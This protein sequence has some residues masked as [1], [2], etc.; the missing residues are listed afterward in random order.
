MLNE[1]HAVVLKVGPHATGIVEPRQTRKGA[2]VRRPSRV[3]WEYLTGAGFM[4]RS[5]YGPFGGRCTAT[6]YMGGPDMAPQTPQRSSRPGGAV[7]LLEGFRE[8]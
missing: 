1:P 6:D 4:G 5:Q 7:A 8:S 3:P 2:T